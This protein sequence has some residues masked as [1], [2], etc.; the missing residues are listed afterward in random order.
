M[1]L[2]QMSD[3]TVAA[4][5]LSL[6]NGSLSSGLYLL[7]IYTKQHCLYSILC[8]VLSLFSPL[9]LYPHWPPINEAKWYA[10]S[11]Q[12]DDGHKECSKDI[13]CKIMDISGQSDT[14]VNCTLYQP[15]IDL[16]YVWFKLFNDR[17]ESLKNTFLLKIA[18]FSSSCGTAASYVV[19]SSS[20]S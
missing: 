14:T 13:T 15:I 9:L 19:N 12:Y 4:F 11:R 18:S 6:V 5:N 10:W 7:K 3:I 16:T 2:I 1:T 20:M 8:L 17:G